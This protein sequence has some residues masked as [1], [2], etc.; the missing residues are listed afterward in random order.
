MN[1]VET[2]GKQ[3]LEQLLAL[4]QMPAPVEVVAVPEIDESC[5]LKIAP[6]ALTPE[7]QELLLG[8]DG[9]AIDAM[10][11]LANALLNID[12]DPE[13]RQPYTI[14][15]ADYRQQR[16]LVLNEAV[17]AAIAE[18]RSTGQEVE[19]P[20]LSSAERRQVHNLFKD[21][22]D[23]TTESRGAEPNRRIFVRLSTL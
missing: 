4:M 8:S 2:R 23:L 9:K 5:W 7:Q 20:P 3:W 17:E 11:Y 14:D 6:E 22:E 18:V 19:M 10:Q 1:E 13:Q 15:L 21:Y 16:Q 12:Q